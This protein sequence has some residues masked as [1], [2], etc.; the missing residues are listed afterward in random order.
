MPDDRRIPLLDLGNI[1]FD[2]HFEHA[3]THWARAGG[4]AHDALAGRFSMDDAYARHETG[5]LGWDGFR[6]AL[7]EQFGLELSDADWREGWARVV[8]HARPDVA[9]R[10]ADLSATGPVHA[11]SNT[12]PSH[13]AQLSERFA[14]ELAPFERVFTSCEL[15]LRKPEPEAFRAVADALGVAPHRLVFLDDT[16]ANVEGA[17]AAGLVA[18]HVPDQASVVR[19][20]DELLAARAR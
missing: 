6:D 9:A 18:H 11:F 17:R 4:L 20:L 10:I 12:N 2:V 3:L 7:A 13:L 14:A 8:G 5:H 16:T 19:A 15:G 1:L